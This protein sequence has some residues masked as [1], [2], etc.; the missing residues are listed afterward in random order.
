[1]SA[2]CALE[3]ARSVA[4]WRPQGQLFMHINSVPPRTKQ[5]ACET[6][7]S[8]GGGYIEAA[9]MAPMLRQRLQTPILLGGAQARALT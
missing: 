7:E 4:L 1:M 9:V 3:V 5:L 2:G 6:I 8:S